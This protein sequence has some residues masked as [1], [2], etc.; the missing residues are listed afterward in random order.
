MTLAWSPAISGLG[1]CPSERVMQGNMTDRRRGPQEQHPSP[2]PLSASTLPQ[3]VHAPT[4][5]ASLGRSGSPS[6]GSALAVFWGPGRRKSLSLR[7]EIPGSDPKM[8]R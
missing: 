4:G 3:K 1:P 8:M 2:A 7:T 6:L 5:H